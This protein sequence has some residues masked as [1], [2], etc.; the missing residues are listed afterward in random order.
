[1]VGDEWER[2]PYRSEVQCEFWLSAIVGVFVF[3]NPHLCSLADRAKWSNCRRA[4]L[5]GRAAEQ[6]KQ[7]T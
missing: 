6:H 1:V 3:L 5:G 7:E 4:L 2:I